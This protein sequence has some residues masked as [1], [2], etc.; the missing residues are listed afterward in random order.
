MQLIIWIIIW[1]YISS[2]FYRYW[3]AKYM[4]KV[5]WIDAYR[6]FRYYGWKYI[7]YNKRSK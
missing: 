1:M 5:D 7:L 4:T 3:M 6:A 2:C